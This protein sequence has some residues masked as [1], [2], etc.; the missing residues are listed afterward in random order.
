MTAATA[1][2][3]PD[4]DDL[5][6]APQTRSIALGVLLVVMGV[7]GLWA[8]FALTLDK[9]ALLENPHFQ[10]D[11][12]ISVLVQ[13]G[14]NLDS[15]QGHVFGFSNPLLGL[16]CFPLPIVMG[17][18]ML[19]GVR[20]PRW[21]W[22]LFNVGMFFAIGFVAWLITQS[23]FSLNTLCPYCMLVW[24]VTIPA[25]LATTF[26]NLREGN[27]PLGPLGR[28]VGATLFAWTPLITLACYVI[29][30]VTAQV[31]LDVL[32]RL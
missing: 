29:F 4:S 21:W 8:A 17:V 22:A 23:I 25:S 26:Y 19:A 6:P 30:A 11:C 1:T 20:F 28:R 31:R 2:R 13:C 32:H 15:W 9:I 3:D 24:S 12:N 5:A 27:L 10:P 14:K 18:G 7:A 16:I